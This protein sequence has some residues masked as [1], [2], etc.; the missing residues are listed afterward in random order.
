MIAEVKKA[1]VPVITGKITAVQPVIVGRITPVQPVIVG[2]IKKD[3]R[4]IPEP[5]YEVSNKYGIT[6]IIGD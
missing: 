2:R 1:N 3:V 6:L 4:E 5:L